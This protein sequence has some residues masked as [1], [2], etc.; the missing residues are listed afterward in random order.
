MRSIIFD[1]D[2][3]PVDTVYAHTFAWHRALLD[4]G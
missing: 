2:G 3:T 1:L 4:D